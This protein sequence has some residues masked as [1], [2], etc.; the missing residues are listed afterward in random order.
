M[1]ALCKQHSESKR[2]C[3]R[4]RK[5]IWPHLSSTSD[6][7]GEHRTW[8]PVPRLFSVCGSGRATSGRL[9]HLS[10]CLAVSVAWHTS[11]RRQL[12][13]E[14][15]QCAFTSPWRSARESSAGWAPRS[16]SFLSKQ[17]L[18]FLLVFSARLSSSPD[19][20]L[21]HCGHAL[22]VTLQLSLPIPRQ[23]L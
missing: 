22:T 7:A 19:E 1:F 12:G 9:C 16:V 4:S 10:P 11:R 2:L 18:S 15:R 23:Q 21:A 5:S 6:M 17:L 13:G 3:S 20:C 14:L 8:S